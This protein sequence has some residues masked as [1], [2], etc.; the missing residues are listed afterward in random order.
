MGVYNSSLEEEGFSG[1]VELV[2]KG[3]G[4]SG[5]ETQAGVLIF[6]RLFNLVNHEE[7]RIESRNEKEEAEDMGGCFLKTNLNTKVGSKEV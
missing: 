6:L 1:G 2:S 3:E 5:G 7:N 4:V